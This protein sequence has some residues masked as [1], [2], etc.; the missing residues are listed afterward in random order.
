MQFGHHYLIR[1]LL[2]SVHKVIACSFQL[3]EKSIVRHYK[4][5]AIFRC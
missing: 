5:N 1:L 3:L 2:I 4:D